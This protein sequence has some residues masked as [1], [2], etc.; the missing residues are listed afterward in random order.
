MSDQN[1]E[2]GASEEALDLELVPEDTSD[3][4]APETGSD[5]L[6]DIQDPVAR[7]EAKKFRA[8][9]RRTAKAPETKAPETSEFLTK[10]DFYKTNEKTAVK[11]VTADPEIK[12]VWSQIVPFYTPRRDRKSVV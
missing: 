2:G 11:A 8:I 4:G 3:E 6:D 1:L 5:P 10:A 7:A 12:A 9:A